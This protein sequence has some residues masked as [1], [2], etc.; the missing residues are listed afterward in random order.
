MDRGSESPN[1]GFFDQEFLLPPIQVFDQDLEGEGG[2]YSEPGVYPSIHTISNTPFQEIFSYRGYTY[3]HINPYN[4]LPPL[5][6]TLPRRQNHE[7][8]VPLFNDRI[9]LVYNEGLLWIPHV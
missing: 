2:A 6:P 3:E 9:S 8:E 1:P 7:L 5:P 4:I